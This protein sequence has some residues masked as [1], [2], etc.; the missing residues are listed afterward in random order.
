[1]PHQHDCCKVEY[2]KATNEQGACFKIQKWIGGVG[3][4]PTFFFFSNSRASNQTHGHKDKQVWKS[5]KKTE[6]E[7]K[8]TWLSPHAR[9][10]QL[11]LGSN[12]DPIRPLVAE[13]LNIYTYWSA[14]GGKPLLV[15]ACCTRVWKKKKK[16][17]WVA[18]FRENGN[19]NGRGGV[20]E[21]CF[22]QTTCPKNNRTDKAS[23]LG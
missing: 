10:N 15:F 2:N 11:Q 7:I 12:G 18:R 5:I 14:R 16:K 19:T 3:K 6:R 1:M 8:E 23:T 17:P 4:K 21:Y 13:M 22:D 20:F 9:V